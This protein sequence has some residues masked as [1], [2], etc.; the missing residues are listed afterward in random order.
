MKKI[1][2][3]KSQL[4][5]LK[6]DAQT[7][8]NAKKVDEAK[9]KMEEAKILKEAISLQEQLDKE[10]AEI[11]NKEAKDKKEGMTADKTKENASAIRAMIKKVTGAPLTEAE[12]ALLLPSTEH[13]TGEHGE[14][15]ILPEDISTLIH[16]KNQT[17]QKFT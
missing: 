13:T 1:D 6:E 14:S 11:L 15:Y 5:T 9:A 7:L 8:L 12:N 16:K 2:E 3:L 10:E 4:E 17:V